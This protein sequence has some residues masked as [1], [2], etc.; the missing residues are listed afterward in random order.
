M[1]ISSFIPLAIIFLIIVWGFWAFNQLIRLQNQLKAAWADIDVQLQMRHD[2]VPQLVTTVK[3]YASYESRILQEVTELRTQAQSAQGAWQ[4][5]LAEARLEKAL[6]GI[7]ALRE[8][9]PDL[10]AN[11]NF[12]QLSSSL[13][14]IENKLQYARRFYN[15]AVRDLNTRIQRVP[16]L[17]IAKSFGFAEAQF[18][19][20]EGQAR[21]AVQVEMAS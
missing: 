12:M 2:L 18:F 5:G 20:A 13:I 11:E 21:A 6:L 8:D 9:Y 16:D 4:Q 7:L 10:K 17:F 15:G 1:S 19:Q 14:E 3:R